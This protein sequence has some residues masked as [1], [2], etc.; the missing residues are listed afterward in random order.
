MRPVRTPL[1]VVLPLVAVTACGGGGDGAS[2]KDTYLAAAEKVC[3]TANADQKAL[4]TPTAAKELSG[5]VSAV[6]AIAERSTTALADLDAPEGD[7]AAL[8]EH[9]LGPLEGQLTKAKKYAVDVKRAS[10]D[11]DQLALLKLFSDPPNKTVADLSWMRSYGFRE[12][13]DATDTS[14]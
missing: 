7:Q 2:A 9:V 12:C 10:D 13:V 8:Q 1:L 4:K 14:G 6:V 3:A 11:N 5:Y